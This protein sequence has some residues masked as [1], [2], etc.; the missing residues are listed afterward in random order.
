MISRYVPRVLEALNCGHA[1]LKNLPV[2]PRQIP[3][4][5]N[6]SIFDTLSTTTTTTAALESSGFTPMHVTIT[7]VAGGI[8]TSVAAS[9][10]VL[11]HTRKRAPSQ[12]DVEKASGATCDAII[13]SSVEFSKTLTAGKDPALAIPG[14]LQLAS[15]DIFLDEANCV[16]GEGGTDST[17]KGELSGQLAEKHG[18]ERVAVK[19]FREGIDEGMVTFELAMLNSL[20]KRSRRIP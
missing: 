17:M 7:A 10:V 12:Q 11:Y 16:I 20:Q 4:P 13:A 15:D 3:S 2:W 9:M 14:Y 8:I 18:F 19:E 5:Q 1:S 6:A